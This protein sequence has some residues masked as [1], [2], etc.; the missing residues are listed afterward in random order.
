M[1]KKEDMCLRSGTR[2]VQLPN[3][4]TA[5]LRDEQQS[6]IGLISKNINWSSMPT[7]ASSKKHEASPSVSVYSVCMSGSKNGDLTM[8]QVIET[9][10]FGKF[11]KQLFVVCGLGL[12]AD[13]CEVNLL[14]FITTLTQ[15]EWSLNNEQR[16][17][18]ASAVFAGE[19]FGGFIWGPVS[20]RYGR[21]NAFL[22]SL[23][24]SALLGLAS[25]FSTSFLMLVSLRFLVGVGVAGTCVPFDILIEMIPK[26]WRSTTGLWI[27]SFWSI[28]SLYV[29]GSAWLIVESWGWRWLTALS[30]LPILVA[31]F[32]YP[33]LP[34]SPRW[35]MDQGRM[36]EAQQII[37][38]IAR[39][40][41]VV[42]NVKVRKEEKQD[43]TPFTTQCKSMFTTTPLS[44]IT[45]LM[46]PIWLLA[47]FSY[48]G[49]IVFDHKVLP[50][51]EGQKFDYQSIIFVCGFEVFG[52][53]VANLLCKVV[54]DE[55]V[56]S[57]LFFISGVGTITLSLNLSIGWLVLLMGIAR[58]A[59]FGAQ[60]VLWV[61]TPEHYPTLIR[62]TAHGLCFI[63]SRI[64]CFAT[65]YWG[66]SHFS[67]LTITVVYFAA[68]LF[69]AFL[70]YFLPSQKAIDLEDLKD[71]KARD[72]P[73]KV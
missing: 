64:G 49:V 50:A 12:M 71:L 56:Q 21:R 63:S 13:A 65:P 53:I 9:L 5:S 69:A 33:W 4:L 52:L 6:F 28:G 40:N 58:G 47:S 14:T 2:V 43:E 46:L 25:A 70:S 26:A 7:V 32:C 3:D 27:M 22:Y 34:E 73:S 15:E 11:Q 17:S 72:N 48:F 68:N 38:R 57:L 41:G 61:I 36:E 42:G 31:L 60:A 10:G 29:A 19:F 8:G 39:V 24:M 37:D 18:I 35:L 45:Y 55:K 30:S 62:A 54:S 51:I 16:A 59:I 1:E 20:D 44:K 66:D 23:A 67:V